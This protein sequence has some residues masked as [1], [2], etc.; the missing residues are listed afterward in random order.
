MKSKK[1]LSVVFLILSMFMFQDLAFADAETHVWNKC[2][3]SRRNKLKIKVNGPGSGCPKEKIKEKLAC[4]QTSGL[5]VVE[6][7][8]MEDGVGNPTCTCTPSSTSF[9]GAWAK[10]QVGPNLEFSDSWK[11]NSCKHF[12][13]GG[14]INEAKL[15]KG[16]YMPAL[17]PPPPPL[18][19]GGVQA[20]LQSGSHTYNY[21]K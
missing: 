5:E 14:R 21:L 2:K 9:H 15:E 16:F 11:T 20:T 18:V 1:N 3:N 8:R 4:T 13:A 7:F 19:D 12:K 17:L 10:A 6:N